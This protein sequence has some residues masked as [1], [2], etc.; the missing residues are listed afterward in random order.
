MTDRSLNKT[1]SYKQ[2]YLAYI[3]MFVIIL[4]VIFLLPA[5]M[6]QNYIDTPRIPQCRAWKHAYKHGPGGWLLAMASSI[7]EGVV[8][9]QGAH[10]WGSSLANKFLCLPFEQMDFLGNLTPY[11]IIHLYN[12]HANQSKVLIYTHHN[13]WKAKQPF[14]NQTFSIIMWALEWVRIMSV[15]SLDAHK[16]NNDSETLHTSQRQMTPVQRSK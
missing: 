1:F 11:T 6:S 13:T 3:H 16:A 4:H 8:C 5:L 7:C 9:K 12:D 10:C 15:F 14:Q 2:S